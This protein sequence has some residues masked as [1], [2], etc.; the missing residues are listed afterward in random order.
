M[1]QDIDNRLIFNAADMDSFIAKIADGILD[2]FFES[3]GKTKKE[4]VFIGLQTGGIPLAR[5][6]ASIIRSKH[7]VEI[8]V[9][10]LDI[11]MYRDDFGTRRTI[12]MIRETHIPFDI[13]NKIIILADDVLQTGRSIRAALDA[14]TDF[15]RPS[16][17]RLAVLIDRG[18]REFPIRA[19]YVGEMISEPSFRRVKIEW[20]EY[21]CEDAVY[22]MPRNKSTV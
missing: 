17:I 10:T 20:R 18:L 9:G 14:I 4:I 2:E 21:D 7:D 6:I 19:D 5:R 22:S 16:L 11:S 3:D 1:E 15:G 8:P 13:D 12:P